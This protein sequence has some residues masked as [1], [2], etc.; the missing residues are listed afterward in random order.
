M[1]GP[2]PT[3]LP[4]KVDLGLLVVHLERVTEAQMREETD[5]D[6]D[7]CTPDGAWMGVDD[8]RILLLKSL[9]GAALRRVFFHE[10]KHAIVDGDYLSS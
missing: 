6:T 4:R 9:R 7:D 2:L 8:C 1:P 10:L 3:R 5:C